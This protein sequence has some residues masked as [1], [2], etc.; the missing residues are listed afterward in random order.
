MRSWVK[1]C[2]LFWFGRPSQKIT[3]SCLTPK[4]A[5]IRLKNDKP[6]I[7]RFESIHNHSK[8]MPTK[9]EGNRTVGSWFL[10]KRLKMMMMI[11][12]GAR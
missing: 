3:Q 6:K 5:K 12:N 8:K 10:T 11:K 7:L 9:F 1:R 2:S 4:I